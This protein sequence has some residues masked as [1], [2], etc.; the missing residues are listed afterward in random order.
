MKRFF[1]VISALALAALLT[2]CGESSDSSEASGG[3]EPVVS[4]EAGSTSSSAI[5]EP[6][7]AQPEASQPPKEDSRMLLNIEVNGHLL[8]AELADNSSARALLDLLADEAVTVDMRDYAGM[9]KVGS[10]PRSLPRNDEQ[11]NTDAGDLILYQGN[12]FVIYYDT[13]SWSLT[14]L[15]KITNAS[16]SELRE[17][18]G[19]GSVTAALSIP[20]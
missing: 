18:L 16:K 11:I 13:N 10:L 17:I 4:S 14:R 2:A 3:G 8:T 20:E 12:Q 1:T 6:I 7:Q 15:G 5:A 19:S 9:E